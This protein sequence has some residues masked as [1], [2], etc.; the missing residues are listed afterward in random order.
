[1]HHSKLAALVNTYL[2]TRETIIINENMLREVEKYGSAPIPGTELEKS[3][4]YVPLIA[5]D[6]ARGL[7]SLIDHEREHAFS[8][9]NVRLLQTLANSMSVALENA[10]LFDETQ[11]LLQETEQRAA[12]LSAISTVSQA[13][14]A[15]PELDK[16]IQL[17]GSQTRQIFN[18][19]IAYLALLD[20]QTNLI[21]FPYQ[22]GEAFTTLNFGEGLTSKIIASSEALLIN[23]DIDQRRE[24]IGA[25]PVGRQALSYLGVPIKSGSGAIGVLSV[26][27]TTQEDYFDDDSLHLL[28][29]IAANAGAAIHTARLHAETIRR[30][31]EMA[32]LAEIG[33]DISATLDLGSVLDQI[34]RYA[35]DLLHADSSAVFLPDEAQPLVY[36]AIAAIGDI[37]AELKATEI[38]YGEGILGDIVRSGT[39]EIVNDPGS[40]P[41][42]I[43]LAGTVDEEHEHMMVAPLLSAVGV[44]GLMAVW[45]TGQRREFEQEELNFLNGLSQQ[46]AIAIDNARLFAEAQE[47]KQ[48]AEEAN[49][50]K[51]AFLATMSHELRTP[52]NAIIGFTR[53]VRRKGKEM[54]PEKQLSNLEK[55]LASAEHLLG[56]INTVLD[57]AKIEA[58]RMD[59]V[60]TIFDAGKLVDMCI[61]TSQPMLKPGCGCGPKPRSNCRTFTAIKTK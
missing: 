15:E 14:V 37:V 61:V 54:L 23:R 7:I 3:A 31:E 22:H 48:Q 41:R 6:Q 25:T 38:G 19:D 35:Q 45:R 59:V 51:S 2:R 4:V 10:R 9:A 49:Q 30:A 18:A 57:I 16:L 56:L 28:Q 26:Q 32:A 39:A 8:D 33:K 47:A 52:L 20:A 11:R 34:T 60:P 40:D 55:V 42:A 17:I 50:A 13:L 5:G 12:E 1:M 53:I 27:S 21:H 58:G 46:A 29:T 24:Q 44:R 43:T 36:T